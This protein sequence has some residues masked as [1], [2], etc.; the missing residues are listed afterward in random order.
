[1]TNIVGGNAGKMPHFDLG[2]DGV[3]T[4]GSSK[5]KSADFFQLISV[6]RDGQS[7]IEGQL[8][9]EERSHQP[10]LADSGQYEDLVNLEMKPNDMTFDQIINTVVELKSSQEI[11]AGKNIANS[12]LSQLTGIVKSPTI[13]SKTDLEEELKSLIASISLDLD[14][15]QLGKD[16]LA[17]K[18]SEIGLKD[19]TQIFLGLLGENSLDEKTKT[20]DYLSSFFQAD[21]LYHAPLIE[22]L[23]ANAHN[24]SDAIKNLPIE[25]G[26]DGFLLLNLSEI[27][28]V[29][30][31]NTE[32]I[33]VNNLYLNQES[34]S[35]KTIEGKQNELGMLD[36]GIELSAKGLKAVLSN[37]DHE[38]LV[39]FKEKLPLDNPEDL[40]AVTIDVPNK[41]L[42]A[43][44]VTLSLESTKNF[45][46]PQ[47]YV[48]IKFNGSEDAARFL[49]QTGD[50]TKVESI[51][52]NLQSVAK[53][54]EIVSD[55]G[56][57]QSEVVID[58]SQIMKSFHN[59]KGNY[60]LTENST[61]FSSER[62][63]SPDS[64]LV[65]KIGL[66]EISS[67]SFAKFLKDRLQLAVNSTSRKINFKQEIS[68]FIKT[69][70]TGLIINEIANRVVKR[71]LGLGDSR[72]SKAELFLSSADVI[73]YRQAIS[74]SISKPGREANKSIENFFITDLENSDLVLKSSDEQAPIMQN[75]KFTKAFAPNAESSVQ[76]NAEQNIVRLETT[77]ERNSS[78]Q[79]QTF[80]QR[81][82]LLE[83]QFSSRL[84]NA[85]L[86]QAI[87]SRENFDLILE[88]E[89]FGKVRV[90]VSIDSSQI[91][92]KL[93]AENSSTLSILRASESMLQ[94]IS[95]QNG[96]KLAEYNV[97]LNNNAQNNEGSHGRKDEK[98]QNKNLNE[99]VEVVEETRDPFEENDD[100]HSLN[101]IA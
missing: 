39:E 24:L 70:E 8:A 41:N 40:H 22:N 18:N 10:S 64:P 21:S 95:E 88:P 97:E 53:I 86:D 19:D 9:N 6:L 44:N 77:F 60:P 84:A 49:P 65:D 43:L 31:E 27:N 14:K 29:S 13:H 52:P 37:L 42:A 96:L 81:I 76:S 99:S 35:D 85:L 87:N 61:V 56:L 15:L 80:S 30:L 58:Q 54:T 92:V 75:A 50:F 82:S 68:N 55:V 33:T 69:S 66:N 12:T 38:N 23:N 36:L 94:T 51:S 57:D 5:N 28:A 101:L 7:G 79:A 46:L 16:F 47:A 91:D 1:M 11:G 71:D 83:A 73:G 63:I 72:S 3:A 93:I 32:L 4:N 59:I 90:N 67:P 89:T 25:S 26:K 48:I 98:D 20:V 62:F 34:M 100:T 74:G 2:P 45:K 78:V 17:I